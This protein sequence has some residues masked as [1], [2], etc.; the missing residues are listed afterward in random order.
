MEMINY[1]MSV[2]NSDKLLILD[3]IVH[4]EQYL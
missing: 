4:Q 1:E 2:R 3:E